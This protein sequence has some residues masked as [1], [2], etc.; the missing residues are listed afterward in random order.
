MNFKYENFFTTQSINEENKKKSQI[1]THL[2]TDFLRNLEQIIKQENQP[3]LAPENAPTF[4]GALIRTKLQ[5]SYF[6]AIK[7]IEYN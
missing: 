3:T 5:E 4:A 6:L 7:E 1:V 2:F